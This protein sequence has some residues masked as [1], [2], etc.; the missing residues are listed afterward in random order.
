MTGLGTMFF[1]DGRKFKGEFLDGRLNG[2]G[3][4]TV[5]GVT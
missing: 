4:L 1:T 5:D 2:E 3:E